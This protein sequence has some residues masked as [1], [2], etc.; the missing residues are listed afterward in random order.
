MLQLVGSA[1]VPGAGA[2]GA[3]VRHEPV[4]PLLARRRAPCAAAPRECDMA[5]QSHLGSHHLACILPGEALC[6]LRQRGC[7]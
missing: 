3:V 6:M 2:D 7:A 1:G 5:L 4:D